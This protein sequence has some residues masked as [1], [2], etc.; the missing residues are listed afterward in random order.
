[1]R[2]RRTCPYPSGPDALGLNFGYAHN[3]DLVCCVLFIYLTPHAPELLAVVIPVTL[4]I[5][6][7]GIPTLPSA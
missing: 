5:G 4:T 7:V 3:P 2:S 1:M 6:T